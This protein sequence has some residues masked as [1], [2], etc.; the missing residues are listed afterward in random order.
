MKTISKFN[1]L[2]LSLSLLCASGSS[3]AAD[4]VTFQLDWLPGETKHQYSLGLNKDFLQQRIW[5]SPF[6]VVKVLQMQSPK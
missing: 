5:M 6:L 4:K 3:L 2:A 1:K